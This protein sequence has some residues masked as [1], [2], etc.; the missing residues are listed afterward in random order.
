MRR[1]S[2]QEG[3]IEKKFEAMEKEI[4]LAAEELQTL[5]RD[6][7]EA[8]DVLLLELEAMRRC[9]LHLHPEFEECYGKLKAEVL[10]EVDPEEL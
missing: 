5:K 3:E 4:A 2:M 9:L 6:Q 1:F 8:R 7:R 10:Q